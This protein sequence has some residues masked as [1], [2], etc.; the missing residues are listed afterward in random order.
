MF[1]ITSK[2][3]FMLIDVLLSA[4]LVGIGLIAMAVILYIVI[5][6]VRTLIRHEINSDINSNDK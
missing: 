3:F 1:T 5:S 6:V 4:A 2:I